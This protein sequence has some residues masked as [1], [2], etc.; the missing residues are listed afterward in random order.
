MR[1]ISF[2]A[3]DDLN[4]VMHRNVSFSNGVWYRGTFGS[5]DFEVL[6]AYPMIKPR[7]ATGLKDRT[8]KEIYEGDVL[9]GGYIVEYKNDCFVVEENKDD[10][11]SLKYVLHYN[12]EM[13][14]IGNIYENPDLI[15]Q[16]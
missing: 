14:V 15:K 5:P 6:G 8:G 3:W 16:A 1:E 11:S 10:W 9:S 13:E 12:P 2:E 4:K 7:Q